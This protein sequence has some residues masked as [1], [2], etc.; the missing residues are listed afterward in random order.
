M[1]F[2][3]TRASRMAPSPPHLVT[4][5]PP[6]HHHLS[7]LHHAR[8][9]ASYRYHPSLPP[10]T[11]SKRT[12]RPILDTRRPG[13]RARSRRLILSLHHPHH[14]RPP[15]ATTRLPSPLPYYLRPNERH[16]SFWARGERAS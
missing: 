2:E 14:H 1:P 5:I 16:E 11:T 10:Q 15:T 7:L 13:E 6:A 8:S 3:T 12:P 9:T 4:S